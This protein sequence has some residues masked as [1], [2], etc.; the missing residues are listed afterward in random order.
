M[1]HLQVIYSSRP[2]GYDDPTLGAI[3]FAARHF[4][5]RDGITGALICREDIFLQLLEGPATLVA[6][7]FQRIERDVRHVE[8][9]KRW[10]GETAERLFPDW[11]MRHDPLHSWLWSPEEIIAGALQ[12]TTPVAIRDVFVRLAAI[13]AGS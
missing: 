1:P 7:T 6:A 9:T 4:N 11:A 10:S 3:L 13:P 2:F 8:V 12:S 5:K